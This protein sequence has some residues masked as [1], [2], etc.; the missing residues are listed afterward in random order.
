MQKVQPEGED[1]DSSF[2]AQATAPQ[3]QPRLT[4]AAMRANAQASEALPIAGSQQGGMDSI[5]VWRSADAFCCSLGMSW[6]GIT[7][8]ACHMELTTMRFSAMAVR[9]LCWKTLD[10]G[11]GTRGRAWQGTAMS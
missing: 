9:G 7:V 3:V 11:A 5:R 8:S 10:E 1:D 4:S 2:A 6:H